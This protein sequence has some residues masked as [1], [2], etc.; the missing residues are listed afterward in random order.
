M[1][2][3]LL[4]IVIYL[5]IVLVSS[6][7]EAIAADNDIT[8][9]IVQDENTAVRPEPEKSSGTIKY[10][11]KGTVIA[12]TSTVTN[13][14]GNLWMQ[15]LEGYYVYSE[16]LS[17]CNLTHNAT[18][19]IKNI[20]TGLYLNQYVDSPF[21]ITNNSRVTTFKLMESE[22]NTQLFR[23]E[24]VTDTNIIIN[25]P[26]YKSNY[27][28][29]VAYND[30]A[31]ARATI[32]DKNLNTETWTISSPSEDVYTFNL[33]SN[34]N[35]ILTAQDGSQNVVIDFANNHKQTWTLE[36]R[37]CSLNSTE[38]F[39]RDTAPSRNLFYYSSEQNKFPY[40][41]GNCTWYVWGRAYEILGDKPIFNGNACSF[42][43]YRTNYYGYD[44]D[45]PRAGSVAVWGGNYGH[46][47]I[48]EEVY[49][50][51]SILVSESSYG[52]FADGTNFRLKH[53]GSIDEMRNIA[54][55]PNFEPTGTIPLLGFIYLK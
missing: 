2:K 14:Y 7:T 3:R 50:D 25:A 47:A 11:S 52:G 53:Y 36:E 17:Q 31:G 28:I 34:P 12:C 8:L 22:I 35:M 27:A 30:I 51:G 1:K 20:D 16:R 6:N 39:I 44:T 21:S 49:E 33:V 37:E 43:N 40:S 41:N 55:N 4:N 10:L 9:Y 18:Y 19:L 48:V 26:A 42:W 13:S 32:Y 23:L 54:A 45:I 5:F 29:N 46:V 38:Y 15:T 24:F